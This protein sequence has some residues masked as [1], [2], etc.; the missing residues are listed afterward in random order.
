MII[1]S[2]FEDVAIFSPLAVTAPPLSEVAMDV[3][4]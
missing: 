1:D 2:D 3:D 4:F